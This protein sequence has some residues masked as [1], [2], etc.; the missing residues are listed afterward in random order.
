VDRAS[1]GRRPKFFA[2]TLR[3]P[4]LLLHQ[5]AIGGDSQA[6]VVM[7][8]APA[9]SFVVAHPQILFQVLVAALDA[10][11]HLGLKHHALDGRIC[12][13]GRLDLPRFRMRVNAGID[14]ADQGQTSPEG[15]SQ[16]VRMG[17][18]ATISMQRTSRPVWS[19]PGRRPLGAFETPMRDDQHY[20]WP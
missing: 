2:C 5:E 19:R 15:G 3:V 11:A 4:Q 13:Q 12:A 16:A 9:L 14:A 10:P 8:A 7:E 20:P 18:A 1:S 17:T 6:R